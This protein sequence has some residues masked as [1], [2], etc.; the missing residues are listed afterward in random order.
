MMAVTIYDVAQ[1]AGVSISTVSRVLNKNPNVLGETRQRVLK[2]IAELD[3]KPNPIARGLVV[4]QTNLIEVFFSWSGYQFNLHSPW[5]VGLLNGINEVVQENQ[6]GLLINTIAG[7]FDP[8]EVYRRVFQNAMDGVLMVSPYLEEAD[9]LQMMDNRV[10][11]I[12]V[13]YRTDDPRMDYVDSDNVTSSVDVVDHLVKLGH[14]KIAFI[15]GQPKTSRNASDRLLGYQ[16]GLEKHGLTLNPGYVV[17]GD[18]LRGSGGE[19]MKKLLNLP[20]RPTAVFAAN[21]LMALGAWDVIEKE[22]LAVGKDIA[23]VGFDDITEAFT[24]PYSLTTVRQDYRAI[25]IEAARMLIEKI[26][27]SEPWKP[28]QVL[29]PTQLVVRQSCGSK[30]KWA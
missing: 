8:Q 20:D 12:L 22:G 28:R 3:F 30:M 27:T 4:K 9:V 16:K 13:G 11:V 15:A 26:H 24:P 7:I 6:Y 5:Y 18:F 2:A 29:I 17:E 10:P 14:K 23:L 19:A 21:D 25:S 1:K